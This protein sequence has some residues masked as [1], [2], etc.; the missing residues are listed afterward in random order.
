MQPPNQSS[1]PDAGCGTL[2]LPGLPANYVSSEALD[3]LRCFADLLL[4]WTKVINLVSERDEAL[5]WSRH[6]EDS[7][8]LAALLPPGLTR[9][10]DLGSGGGLPAIPLAIVSGVPFELIESDQ[11]KASFL[12]E[13]GRV[14]AAPISVHCQRI[15]KSSLAPAALVTARALAPL[16]K[17][18]GYAEAYLQPG[19]VCV[20]PKGANT[21]AELAEARTSWHFTCERYAPAS[22]ERSVVLVV[23]GLQRA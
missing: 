12:R 13:A 10:I 15:E 8:R 16:P 6:I 20:F 4:R 1:P 21:D 2:P 3:R 11:R 5:I 23:R 9:A 7:I 22:S 19:G 14:T 17:L 18:L